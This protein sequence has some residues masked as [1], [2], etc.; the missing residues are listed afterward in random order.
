[1]SS[2]I[3]SYE[4]ST[5]V[6]DQLGDGD[7]DGRPLRYPLLVFMLVKFYMDDHHFTVMGEVN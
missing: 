5:S 1:M 6:K 2:V 7:D 4:H 3:T